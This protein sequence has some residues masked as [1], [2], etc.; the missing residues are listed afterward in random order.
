MIDFRHPRFWGQILFWSILWFLFPLLFTH[1]LRLGWDYMLPHNLITAIASGLLVAINLQFLLP[2]YYRKQNALF[3]IFGILVIIML[4]WIVQNPEFFWDPIASG[5]RTRMPGRASLRLARQRW[6]G[7]TTPLIASFLGS[8]LYEIAI[9]AQ[10]KDKETIRLQKEKLET[11]IKFLKSQINPH[12]LFNALNNIYT[13][14][15]MQSERA[16]DNILRLSEMLRY[17]LYDCN[18]SLVPLRKEVQ[19]I[20]NYVHL[21]RLK[22]S[23][24]LKITLELDESQPELAIAPM[25]FI[26]FVENAFKHSKIEDNDHGWVTI[27]MTVGNRQITYDVSNS[28]PGQDFHKDATGGIGIENVRRRLELLYPGR[29]NLDVQQNEETYRVTLLL[30]LS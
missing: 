29:Y 17:V 24:G 19:Y 5:E 9:Y 13:L 28:R 18:E 14:S 15:L 25:L 6:M 2:L 12:F 4:L 3:L 8:S 30:T 26:P 23:T 22:D 11:E 10:Q 16:P 1:D 20:R 21:F 7:A 27:K